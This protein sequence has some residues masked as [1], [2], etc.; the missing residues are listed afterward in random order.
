M[1][2]LEGTT[3]TT[4]ASLTGDEREVRGV[5]RGGYRVDVDAA[6][7]SWTLDEPADKGGTGLGPTPV[8][9]LLGALVGCFT[10]SL[11]FAARRAGVPIHRIDGWAGANCERYITAVALE[12]AV[13]TSAP[14]AEVRA[15]LPRA[16]HGCFVR[17]ALSKEI[18][19]TVD[20][21]VFAVAGN[22]AG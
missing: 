7:F 19:F 4:P 14:E 13:W 16:E 20:L 8:Q 5:S 21:A 3:T 1:T 22:D 10:M 2:T 6:G 12:L 9:S 15:L 17:Q 11:E 18:E